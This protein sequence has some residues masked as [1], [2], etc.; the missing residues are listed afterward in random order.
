MDADPPIN[1]AAPS[2]D[3]VKEAVA[4]LRGGKAAGICDIS[5]EL[6]KAGGEAMT[7]GLPAVL[8][9][10]W[11]SSTIPP[12]W[13]VVPLWKGK[14]NLQDCNNCRGIMLISIPGKVLAHLVYVDNTKIIDCVLTDDAVTFAE[15]LEI[16]VGHSKKF[17]GGLAHSVMDSLSTII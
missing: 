15:S 8:P 6:I 10:V 1:E 5:M 11:H 3:E 13:L 2:L 4:R 9:A 17:N 14:G 12:D 16:L 7:C